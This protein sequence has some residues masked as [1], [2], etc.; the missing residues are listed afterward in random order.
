MNDIVFWLWGPAVLAVT[1]IVGVL[2]MRRDIKQMNDS[3][4]PPAE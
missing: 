4:H 2:L 3:R 1:G